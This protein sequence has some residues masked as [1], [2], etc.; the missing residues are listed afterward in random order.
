MGTAPWITHIAVI[1]L[2]K[3]NPDELSTPGAKQ[4]L[5]NDELQPII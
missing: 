3:P 1:E 4:L 5:G 2:R